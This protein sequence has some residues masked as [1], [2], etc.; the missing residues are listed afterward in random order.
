MVRRKNRISIY[1][2]RKHGRKWRIEI[3]DATTGCRERPSF[4]S[5][6]EAWRAYED[7]QKEAQ[8][9]QAPTV[10]EMIGIYKAYMVEKGN[11][12]KSVRDSVYRL[13]RFF[14]D[15]DMLIHEITTRKIQA[16]YDFLKESLAVDSHRGILAGVKTFLRW[17]VRQGH[18][19][20][21]PPIRSRSYSTFASCAIAR[22]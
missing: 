7:A 21:S 8:R 13:E 12:E 11:K 18:L 20:E 14:L 19:S 15:Q 17:A 22:P 9:Y 10:G 16:C 5:E 2:P 4:S 3:R 1:A 6:E